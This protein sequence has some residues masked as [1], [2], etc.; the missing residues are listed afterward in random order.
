MNCIDAASVSSL[1]KQVSDAEL[2]EIILITGNYV[3]VI[4]F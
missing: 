4:I 1:W 2:L 3:V